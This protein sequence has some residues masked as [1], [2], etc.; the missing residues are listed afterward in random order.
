[1]ADGALQQPDTGWLLARA[2]HALSSA[3]AAGLRQQGLSLRGYVVLQLAVQRPLAQQALAATLGLDKTTMVAT[4]DEL[5]QA[6]LVERRPDPAD[7]RVRLVAVTDA[8]RGA[9]D[10]AHALVSATEDE[11]LADLG[12]DRATLRRLLETALAGRLGTQPPGGSCV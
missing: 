10:R 4:V 12:D 7:R 1:V 6:R 3:V 11:L 9:L 2:S 8:G 5:E